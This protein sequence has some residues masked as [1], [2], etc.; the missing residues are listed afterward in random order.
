RS[1]STQGPQGTS[2]P[3]GTSSPRAAIGLDERPSPIPPRD[4]HYPKKQKPL[5]KPG[6]ISAQP[7][8]PYLG[9]IASHPSLISSSNCWTSS[10][11]RGVSSSATPA[12]LRVI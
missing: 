7:P 3:L 6:F 1:T 5:P 10:S 9:S 8:Q 12:S 11:N 2:S 4:P